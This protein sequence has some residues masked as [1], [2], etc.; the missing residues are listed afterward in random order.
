[1]ANFAKFRG[2]VRKILHLAVAKLFK[3]CASPWPSTYDIY[4]IK[5]LVIEGWRSAQLC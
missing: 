2:P 5:T 1:M 4:P 3:F